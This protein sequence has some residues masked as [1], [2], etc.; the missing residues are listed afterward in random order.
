MANAFIKNRSEEF[1][2]DIWNSYVLP[3]YYPDLGIQD[4]KK[5]VVIEG[6]RGCGKTSLLRYLSFHSQFSKNRQDLPDNALKT[7]GLYLKADTHYFS[8]FRGGG[9]GDDKWAHVFEHALC[10]A[11]AEQLVES[12]LKIN[13]TPDRESRWGGLE[14][15][16][17]SAA[18]GGLSVSPIPSGH[19]E[20]SAWLR[21]QR[22]HLSRWFKNLETSP[23]PELFSLREMLLG[24]ILEVQDKLPYLSESVFAVFI[25]EYENLL[26]YQQRYLNTLI[27]S[28]E[29]PLIF[30][31]AMKPNG[32]RT[33]MTTGP[34]S[35]Q[36]VSDYRLLPLHK[37]LQKKYDQF[38]A[39]LFFFRLVELGYPETD[40]PIRAHEL[41][42]PD[43]LDK[44][45]TDASYRNLLLKEANRVLPTLS[46]KEVSER[47]LNDAALLHRWTELVNKALSSKEGS[48]KAEDFLDKN[49]PEATIVC[50]SL[51]HQNKTP[52][53]VL[54]E[55]NKLKEGKPSVFK[56]GDWVHHFL[57]GSLLLIFLPF[58]QRANPLYGGFDAFLKLSQTNVRHFLELCHWSI[59]P[60]DT[61]I[62][63]SELSVD[64]DVQAKAAFNAS[65]QFKN[66]VAGCGDSGNRLHALVN[67]LGRLFRLSQ[68]RFSQSEP[69]RTH[70]SIINAEVGEDAK[71]VISEAIKWSV[72]IEAPESKVKG[73]RYESSDYILNPIYAPFFGISY[74]KGRKLEI[75]NI[76]AEAMLVGTIEDYT[77]ILKQYE[78]VWGP[79][80]SDQLS[81]GFV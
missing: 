29:P 7:I 77:K 69:E 45:L 34:E 4:T 67:L 27:K 60:I 46:F 75:S 40:T 31:V 50:A 54:E 51:L 15:L 64:V 18:V 13:A 23:P 36:E 81:L 33:R 48:Y 16:D 68:S 25:D 24:L 44:R 56:E 39:E 58:R 49:H 53:K 63:L 59:D 2:L 1:G 52:V 76:Q 35:I 12:L 21:T 5:S 62:P 11:L 22:Q 17:F 6:G 57:L 38:A 14:K 32:M 80:S 70:F 72:L 55:F 79:E 26:E 3:Y 65:S 43:F 47:I 37:M 20:F 41:Q 9:I 74:N 42:S 28:G 66:E 8:G 30:H 10:L 19:K 61:T 78:S 73:L 71:A